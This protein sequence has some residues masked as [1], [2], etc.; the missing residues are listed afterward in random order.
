MF[1]GSNKRKYEFEN[2]SVD[3]R[4]SNEILMSLTSYLKQSNQTF[5][6]WFEDAV[7][8]FIANPVKPELG[9]LELSSDAVILQSLTEDTVRIV[10]GDAHMYNMSIFEEEDGRV[11]LTLVRYEDPAVEVLYSTDDD[12]GAVRIHSD[13]FYIT[14]N[15]GKTVVTPTALETKVISSFTILDVEL[16][17]EL[18]KKVNSPEFSQHLKA[19]SLS[20]VFSLSKYLAE[21]G[22]SPDEEEPKEVV[23]D[24]FIDFLS[25]GKNSDESEEKKAEGVEIPIPDAEEETAPE[26]EFDTRAFVPEED[27]FVISPMATD[28]VFDDFHDKF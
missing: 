24:D 20:E 2:V 17:E 1:F 10:D 26:K 8:H 12:D 14:W 11:N 25:L 15:N 16:L 22:N 19:K 23:S 9:F 7:G 27:G 4:V 18:Y 5:T 21:F 13:G 6:N 3:S 28:R